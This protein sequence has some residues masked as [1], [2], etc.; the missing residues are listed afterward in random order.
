[1]RKTGLKAGML[2]G[3]HIHAGLRDMYRVPGIVGLMLDAKIITILH[4]L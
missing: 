1:M 3:T 2:P 4:F